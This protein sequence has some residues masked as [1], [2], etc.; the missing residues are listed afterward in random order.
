MLRGAAYRRAYEPHLVAF[1]FVA[2]EGLRARE[3]GVRC[4][5]IFCRPRIWLWTVLQALMD[6]G[7]GRLAEMTELRAISIDSHA[8]IFPLSTYALGST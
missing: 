2:V 7:E 3:A 5:A 1:E 4:N 8:S 6:P